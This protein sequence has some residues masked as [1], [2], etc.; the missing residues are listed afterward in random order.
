MFENNQMSDMFSD[1]QVEM[2]PILSIDEDESIKTEDLPE[3]VPVLPLRNN[4]L[5]PD[6]VIPISVGRDKSIKAVKKAYKEM[7]TGLKKQ[8]KYEGAIELPEKF[9]I[10]I[11]LET[12]TGDLDVALV[13]PEKMTQAMDQ[14][15]T[16]LKTAM[17]NQNTA[18]KTSI[19]A[20]IKKWAD[21]TSGLWAKERDRW[22]KER[23]LCE[24][25]ITA[26]DKS[27][28]DL[29]D[30]KKSENDE[31]ASMCAKISFQA[32]APGCSGDKG[33]NDAASLTDTYAE[34]AQKAGFDKA[35]QTQL[36]VGD[37]RSKVCAGF[38][39]IPVEDDGA[40]EPSSTMREDF[41]DKLSDK[42]ELK[43]S[44]ND[45]LSEKIDAIQKNKAISNIDNAIKKQTKDKPITKC[46]SPSALAKMKN[47][48]GSPSS[49]INYLLNQFLF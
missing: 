33:G 43:G 35:F 29:K 22:K 44:C 46:P 14:K 4:V 9:N 49:V 30:A 31:L 32:M 1:D 12:L 16:E 5:F 38:S 8:F 24:K 19:D 34:I 41:C 37:Y 48:S 20:E 25:M 47:P 2:I 27:L 15:L 21:P 26:Y 42:H 6:V 10:E 39:A 40:S 45:F 11:P 3:T 13:D 28:Q 18:I 36:A 17:T 23:D 7:Y